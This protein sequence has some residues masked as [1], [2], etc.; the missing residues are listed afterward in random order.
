MC[1]CETIRLLHYNGLQKVSS[2]LIKFLS[3]QLILI[4][5]RGALFTLFYS[6]NSV[7][8]HVLFGW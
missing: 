5:D 4:L 1:L 7:C 8:L 2:Q 3:D 6:T